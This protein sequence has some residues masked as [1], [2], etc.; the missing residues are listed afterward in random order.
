MYVDLIGYAAGLFM[1]ISFVPQVA[2]TL[3]TRLADDVSMSMLMLTLCSVV[4]YEI[5]AAIL[6]L[7]P[8][9]IM[10]GIFLVLVS[11]ETFLKI[12][13]LQKSKSK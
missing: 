5:Y 8:V 1:A 2:Q 12:A 7:W 10:N 13:L 11:F 6:G 9:V 4:L 3:R